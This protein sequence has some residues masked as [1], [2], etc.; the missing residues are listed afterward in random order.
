MI[1][2]EKEIMDGLLGY[3]RLDSHLPNTDKRED[4]IVIQGGEC[5]CDH[6]EHRLFRK[7]LSLWELQ[8]WDRE[9][10]GPDVVDFTDDIWFA[11]YKYLYKCKR[12]GETVIKLHRALI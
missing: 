2:I 5:E 9:K 6:G 10:Y 1:T 11:T 12:C 8:D 4:K 7:N 3:N